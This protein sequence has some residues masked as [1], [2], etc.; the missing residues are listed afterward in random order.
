VERWPGWSQD[1]TL[2]HTQKVTMLVQHPSALTR[3]G[4]ARSEEDEQLEQALWASLYPDR[5]AGK[6]RRLETTLGRDGAIYAR[7][8]REIMCA[9]CDL[10][11][12]PL[13]STGIQ[14]VEEPL[15]QT[16]RPFRA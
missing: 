11:L 2:L 16:Q 4:G 10:L 9:A 1:C 12:R 7:Y 5:P 3:N 13:S 14:Q 8:L 6:S 15:C